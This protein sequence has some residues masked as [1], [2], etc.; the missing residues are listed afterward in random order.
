M[1]AYSGNNGQ[2]AAAKLHSPRGLPS[3]ATAAVDGVCAWAIRRR[4][5]ADM[6]HPEHRWPAPSSQRLKRQA[7][8]AVS[9]SA[10]IKFP[11][12]GE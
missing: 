4:A 3:T 7:P 10:N 12:I 11:K 1:A 2:A 8:W 6:P 9:V 5:A